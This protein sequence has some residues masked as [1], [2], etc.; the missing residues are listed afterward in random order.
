VILSGFVDDEATKAR[1]Q[2]I[3]AGV[4]GVKGIKNGLVVKP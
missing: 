2:R 3:A 4:K 1:A